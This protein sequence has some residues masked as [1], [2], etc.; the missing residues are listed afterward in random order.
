MRASGTSPLIALAIGLGAYAVGL[1]L[2]GVVR[3]E[4][5]HWLR[6][7]ATAA[8]ARLGPSAAV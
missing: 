3:A 5:L 6:K 4:H 7:Q 8:V 2:A 1:W